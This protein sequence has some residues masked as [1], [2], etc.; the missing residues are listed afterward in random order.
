MKNLLLCTTNGTWS[1]RHCRDLLP[2]ETIRP[3]SS[4][5]LKQGAFG[6]PLLIRSHSEDLITE[7]HPAHRS[8]HCS[9]NTMRIRPLENLSNTVPASRNSP[10]HPDH[11]FSHPQ[12][13]LVC[14]SSVSSRESLIQKVNPRL[15]EDSSETKTSSSRSLITHLLPPN[16]ATHRTCHRDCNETHQ[17]PHVCL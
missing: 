14:F 10:G 11:T 13:P 2:E 1:T 5:G 9:C 16:R 3:T 15:V 6:L 8:I 17:E 12:P 4:L 7:E